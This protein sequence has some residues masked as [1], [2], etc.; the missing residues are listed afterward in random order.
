MDPQPAISRGE[1]GVVASPRAAGIAEDK[2]TLGI[3]HEGSGLGEIGRGSAVLDHQPIAL[4]NDA[5]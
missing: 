3:I 4:A 1:F 5:A 2:D